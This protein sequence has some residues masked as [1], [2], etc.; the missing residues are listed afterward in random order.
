MSESARLYRMGRYCPE[1]CAEDC[2]F[3]CEHCNGGIELTPTKP[4]L[5]CNK[6]ENLG[7][8]KLCYGKGCAS[9]EKL[10]PARIAAIKEASCK[11]HQNKV[12]ANDN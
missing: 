6:G 4:V 3:I 7:S 5:G 12:T 10:S 9:F 8:S 2:C 1:T 11:S